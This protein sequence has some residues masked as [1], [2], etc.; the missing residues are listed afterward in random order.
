MDIVYHVRL[1]VGDTFG[2]S[3]KSWRPKT[4]ESV[5]PLIEFC[6]KAELRVYFGNTPSIFLMIRSATGPQQRRATPSSGW[7][8]C[9]RGRSWFP[10]VAPRGFPHNRQHAFAALVH[11]SNFSMFVFCSPYGFRAKEITPVVYT[12]GVSVL[13][14]LR[15]TKAVLGGL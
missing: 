1:P 15:R 2:Q 5:R 8:G 9:Q 13:Q 12:C 6:R 11:K 7:G 14:E 4:P 10:G 3:S